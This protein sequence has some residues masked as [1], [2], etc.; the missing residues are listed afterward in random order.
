MTIHARQ[1]CSQYNLVFQP[2]HFQQ[3]KKKKKK[4]IN[5]DQTTSTSSSTLPWTTGKVIQQDAQKGAKASF[6]HAELLLVLTLSKQ[7]IKPAIL[8]KIWKCFPADYNNT[9]KCHWW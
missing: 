2:K 8:L 6:K 7:H 4:I 3:K 9:M 1:K 5:K